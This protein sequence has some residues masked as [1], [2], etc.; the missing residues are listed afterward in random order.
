MAAQSLV[1]TLGK[2]LADGLRARLVTR[3]ILRAEEGRVLG[4]FPTR[5]WPA[6][7]SRHEAQLRTALW[8]VLVRGRAPSPRE[9]CLV[10]LLHA[11]DQVPKQFRADGVTPRQLRERARALAEGEIGGEAVRRAVDAANA[12]VMTAIMATTV[13]TTSS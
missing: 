11:V 8:D 10:S 7:D 5:V 1:T 12:A 13:V 3:G 6:T 4:I 9:A 2:G